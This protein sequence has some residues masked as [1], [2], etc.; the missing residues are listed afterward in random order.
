[1]DAPNVPAGQDSDRVGMMVDGKG[2]VMFAFA[3]NQGM[4]VVMMKSADAGGSLQ[5]MAA[6]PDKK[7][8]DVRTLGVKGDTQSTMGGD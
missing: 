7:Q 5:V 1:M 3:D 6:S 8:I 4:P 2:H